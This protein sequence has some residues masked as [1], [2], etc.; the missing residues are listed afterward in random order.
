MISKLFDLFS[1]LDFDFGGILI[2]NS[3]VLRYYF[4]MQNIEGVLLVLRDEICLFVDFRYYELVKFNVKNVSVLLFENL[5]NEITSVLV[6]KKVNKIACHSQDLPVNTY[7]KFKGWFDNKVEFVLN[8]ALD[9]KIEEHMSVKT[10]L[11]IEKITYAQKISEKVLKDI[12]NF[13]VP[14]VS[15][16]EVARKLN[17]LICQNSDGIAFETIVVSGRRTSLPHGHASNKLLEIGD[18]ITID[19]GAIID[20]Y[21]SDMTRTFCL[22][23]PSLFQQEIYE[24][25]LN[26]QKLAF[27]KIKL[28][29]NCS[30]I[31]LII[32]DYF[33]KYGYEKN[34]GHSLGHGVG[35]KIH[36]RPYLSLNSTDKFEKNMVC[37]VEPGLYFEN[38]FGVR[39]EDLILVD[40]DEIVNLTN[41]DRNL[42]CL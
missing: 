8:S 24:L 2:C 40:Y 19:F 39:I 1:S 17:S 37:T 38:D 4:N 30:Q 22:G 41:F 13:L 10:V 27:E 28:G 23:K 26:A 21:R 3:N 33:K 18:F 20:G 16:I 25:V 15:E 31:D 34:F 42:L 36:E 35:L 12:L 29:V 14:G 11:E 6:E 7:F 9:S 32:R 5:R